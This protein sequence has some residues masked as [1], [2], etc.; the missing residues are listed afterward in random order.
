M[1]IGVFSTPAA[2]ATLLVLGGAV[3]PGAPAAAQSSGQGM[4]GRMQH[5]GM[6]GRMQGMMGG[7]MMGGG[8][9]GMM[10]M[11]R[12]QG[13]MGGMGR[14]QGGGCP[15]H[16]RGMMGGMQGMGPMHGGGGMQ[17]QSMGNMHGGGMG[18]MASAHG[19]LARHDQVRR[20]VRHLP[21]GVETLTESDDPEVAAL[22]K[23][24]VPAMYARMKSG[25]PVMPMHPVFAELA[26]F[27]GQVEEKV[28]L[29]EKGVHVVSTSK[30]KYV[31]NLIRE[32]AKLVDGFVARG[33]AAMHEGRAG[34]GSAQGD[35][36]P[37]EQHQG[38]GQHGHQ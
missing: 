2:V 19:L 30:D 8:G 29:T 23:Q 21:D 13:M 5:G 10:G 35:A 27:A 17:G 15:M 12:M 1:K 20:S 4:M 11:S 16:G 26:R 28:T 7:G 14:M 31:V 33:M 24:H 36:Q 22:L 37:V 34:R 18:E 3:V 9:M 25:R 38:H 6:M 32:H